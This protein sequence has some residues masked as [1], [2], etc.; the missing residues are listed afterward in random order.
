MGCGNNVRK[1]KSI[2]EVFKVPRAEVAT[3]MKTSAA[4]ITRLLNPN[5]RLEGSPQ[6]WIGIEKALGCIVDHRRLQVF[7][8]ERIPAETIE[9]LKQTPQ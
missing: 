1:L 9:R 5:D 2:I 4:Y 7:E 8:V 6:F 3:R